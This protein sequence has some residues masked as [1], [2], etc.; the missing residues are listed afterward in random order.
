MATK[1]F[2][3]L[4]VS[5]LDKSV[6]FFTELGL[7]FAPASPDGRTRQMLISDEAFVLLHT[8]SYFSEFTRSAVADPL[9]AVEVR[10][11][12][13]AESRD[14]VDDL[15]TR[16]VAAGGQSL[17]DAVDQ[18]FMYMRPFRDLDGHQWSFLAFEMPAT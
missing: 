15:V 4:P 7:S 12:L 8:Q 9:T 13:S 11:G 17:G 1:T 5:D 3:N 6:E 14:S 18:G 10:L 2:I 16:A